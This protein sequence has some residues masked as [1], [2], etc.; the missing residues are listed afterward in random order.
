MRYG[1]TY[2]PPVGPNKDQRCAWW[3]GLDDPMLFDTYELAEDHVRR[4]WGDARSETHRRFDVK[5]EGETK[6][7]AVCTKMKERRLKSGVYQPATN[8]E[9]MA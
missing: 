3:T 9:L 6:C 7:K 1:I 5:I 8:K 4:V 2:T